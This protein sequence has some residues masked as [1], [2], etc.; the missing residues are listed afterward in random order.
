MNISYMYLVRA[1]YHYEVG[2]I[3]F[4]I[5]CYDTSRFVP[6]SSYNT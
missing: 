2:I 5:L 1:S 3:L 4:E 6:S